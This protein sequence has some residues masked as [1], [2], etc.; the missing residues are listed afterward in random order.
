MLAR[1]A[2]R[3]KTRFL[4]KIFANRFS[5]KMF[6]L[7]VSFSILEVIFTLVAIL[8]WFHGLRNSNPDFEYNFRYLSW[9]LSFSSLFFAVLSISVVS[10][11]GHH[12]SKFRNL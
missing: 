5:T 10:L 6:S 9:W 11:V 4:G 8:Q 3:R 2:Y 1:M 7:L 12:A